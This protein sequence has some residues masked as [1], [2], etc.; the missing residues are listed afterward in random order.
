MDERGSLARYPLQCETHGPY[1]TGS[2]GPAV[3]GGRRAIGSTLMIEPE[4]AS[5]SAFQRPTVRADITTARLPLDGPAALITAVAPDLLTLRHR[6]T[7][8]D[9]LDQSLGSTLVER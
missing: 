9:E 4:A 3:T 6:L 2:D 8:V 5:N 7:T 1:V